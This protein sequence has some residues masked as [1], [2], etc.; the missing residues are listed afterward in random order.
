VLGEAQPKASQA[1]TR[2]A[3]PIIPQRGGRTL[4]R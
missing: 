1:N 2:I 3:I 4:T